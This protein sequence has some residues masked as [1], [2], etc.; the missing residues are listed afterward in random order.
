MKNLQIPQILSSYIAQN[1]IRNN[2]PQN[3]TGTYLAS[4][5]E[6]FPEVTL[7]PVDEGGIAPAGGDLNG[8]LN[9]LS[10]FYYFTQNGGVYTYNDDVATAI[11]GYP[12]GAVLWYI[13][14]K[15]RTQVVSNIDDNK[16][17]F[18][19][20]ASLIGDSSAPWSMSSDKMA[21]LP[22]GSIVTSDAP[23]QT[24]GLLS[25]NE[26]NGMLIQQADTTYPAFWEYLLS[27]KAKAV[28]G[29]LR[30]SRFNRTQAEY[31]TEYGNKGFCGYY[32]IDED[33]KTVRLP[34]LTGSFLQ[35]V[36]SGQEVDLAAG[37]PNI[38][39]SSQAQDGYVRTTHN[40]SGAISSLIKVGGSSRT[41][42]GGNTAAY[43]NFDASKSDPIYGRSTTVQPASV[44]MFYY[45]VAA[46]VVAASAGVSNIQTTDN[47]VTSLSEASTDTQYP[48]AKCVYDIVG[49]IESLLAQV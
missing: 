46:N 40:A 1:G 31:T 6:G 43:F 33:N 17:N 15:V 47:L 9:L 25:L 32:V 42:D 45:I 11:G 30:Y 36:K 13:T 4:V 21:N 2:I 23:S 49:D 20:D 29:D 35:A 12:K 16:N 38:T 26:P 10:Q 39:G 18:V 22:V 24:V 14:D 48:S 8:M 3:A 37:L 27:N 41:G 44:S 28:A 34:S 19:K 5:E 7:K